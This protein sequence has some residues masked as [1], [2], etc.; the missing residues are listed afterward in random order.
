MKETFLIKDFSRSC[1]CVEIM[2]FGSASKKA[3]IKKSNL[4][5][6]ISI[7]LLLPEKWIYFQRCIVCIVV[8]SS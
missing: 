8:V 5:I 4:S 1:V 3:A 2:F 6:S 7:M